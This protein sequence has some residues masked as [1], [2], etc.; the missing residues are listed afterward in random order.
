MTK[1]SPA[2]T[3]RPLSGVED[4]RHLQT[5]HGQ[6]WGV[7][8][9][10]IIPSHIIVTMA[11]NGG[12]VLGAFDPTG[13]EDCGGMVGF[14]LGW[15]GTTSAG[16]VKHVSHIA[17]VLPAWRG[18]GVGVD[19]KLAQREFILAQR[20]TTHVTWTYDPL[21]RVNGAFNIHRLGATCT[22]YKVNVYGTMTDE[23]NKGMPSDRFQVDWHLE[24]ER[25]AHALAHGHIPPAFDPSQLCRL[26][27]DPTQSPTPPDN[28]SPMAVPLPLSGSPLQRDDRDLL[29]AWRLYVR[30]AMQQ[31]FAAG[32][33]VVDCIDLGE[34]NGWHYI[35]IQNPQS[36]I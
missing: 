35:L 30:T 22:T 4:A 28:G 16:A 6:I 10:E 5:V 25:V 15:L 14:V 33:A 32:Y 20:L 24:S 27:P 17:G 26:L 31:A 1:P 9:G 12:M 7:V 21:Q 29:M 36:T 13:P 23:L 8:P 11:A 18:R 34:G 19:L 3:I 2:T